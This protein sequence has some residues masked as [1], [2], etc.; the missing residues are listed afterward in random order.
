MNF[1]ED[2]SGYFNDLSDEERLELTRLAAADLVLGRE[3]LSGK[4]PSVVASLSR[5]SVIAITVVAINA[6]HYISGGLETVVTVLALSFAAIG[7]AL[8][9]LSYRL[10]ANQFEQRVNLLTRGFNEVNGSVAFQK[11]V[12]ELQNK[13]I[14]KILEQALQDIDDLGDVLLRV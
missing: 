12:A 1:S 13:D 9:H 8:R 6:N 2:Y 7:E 14:A 5:V 11:C 3:A 10:R 4:K